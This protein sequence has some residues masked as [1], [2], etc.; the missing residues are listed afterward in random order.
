M[1]IHV[2]IAAAGFSLFALTLLFI[3]K[4]TETNVAKRLA[5]TLLFILLVIQTLQVLYVTRYISFES[6][7]AFIYLLS[8]GLVGPLFY[9]YSQHIIHTDKKWLFQETGHFML[10]IVLATF[11]FFYPGTFNIVYSLMFLLGGIYMAILA[12]SLFQLRNK[13]TLFK[14]EFLLTAS[15]L[16]WAMVIVIVGLFANQIMT[17]L[18]PAQIIMLA[19]AIAAAMHIQLNYPHLLSTLEELGQRQYQASTLSSVD[20]D[21]VKQRLAS[22]MFEK[23]VYRDTELSL[24]S[25]AE[26]LSLKPHQLSELLNTQLGISF[27]S[28]LRKQRIKA[29]EHLLKTEPEVSVLA[30]GLSVGFSSQSVFYSAFKELHGTAPGQYRRQS[31]TE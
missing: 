19:L 30:I 8:L 29:A 7:T 18:I 14:I 15:F 22:L 3:Q 6:L 27:S 11:G 17:V 20:C 12:L 4:R 9:L 13:R 5:N 23:E 16:A 26:M 10:V 31:L 1:L 24:K 28:Y 25:L 2:S 21:D